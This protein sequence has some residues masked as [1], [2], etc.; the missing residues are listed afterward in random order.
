MCVGLGVAWVCA[1][2]G[3]ALAV[4]AVQTNKSKCSDRDCTRAKLARKPQVLVGRP[5]LKDFLRH[6]DGNSIPNF[7]INC[8]DAINAH[9]I[10]GRNVGSLKGNTTRRTLD[11]IVSNMAHLPKTVMEKCRDV[12][13][14]IDVMFVNCIPFFLSVS[15]F[16]SLSHAISSCHRCCP[17]QPQG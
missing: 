12:T 5:E 13:L 10:F 2:L 1:G 9:D 6:I 16:S 4:S 17:C 8:Q 15:R 3:V 11:G 14:C 7:P